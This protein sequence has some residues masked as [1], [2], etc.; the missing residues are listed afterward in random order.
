MVGIGSALY[1]DALH[2]SKG[3]KPLT[4]LKNAIQTALTHESKPKVT[5]KMDGESS[6]RVETML[7]IVS[8]VPLIG[9]NMLI[10]PNASLDDGYLDVS[11]YPN[12]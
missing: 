11:L 7:A 12:F 5:I 4:S 2:T 6:V 10:D 3:K 1:T 9:P 8:N